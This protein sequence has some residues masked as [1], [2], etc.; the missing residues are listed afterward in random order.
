MSSLPRFFSARRWRLAS[1]LVLFAYISGHL[2]NH[3]LGLLSLER[4]EAML[5]MSMAIWQSRPGTILLYGSAL[6][7]FSLALRSIYI[8]HD[9]RFP[10]VEIV[11]FWAGFSLPLLLIGH[12]AVTRLTMALYDVKPDYAGIVSSIVAGGSQE[13][14]IA[15]LAPGWLHGCLGLWISL[16]HFAL[17]RRLQ[18]LLIA[19][20]VV[21]PILSAAGFLAMSRE[22]E[23]MGLVSALRDGA[24]EAFAVERRAELTAWKRDM[25]IGY[26]A[27]VTLALLLGP[28]R[29]GVLR[30]RAV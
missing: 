18:P 3:T 27:I 10:F 26:L 11:R 2:I 1:G 16:R 17:M 15:L 12:I 29:R 21:L 25:T 30:S 5:R 20:M 6:L 22:V 8:R 14:Q 28:I 9:W 4:A 23:A 24:Q 7:H 19:G 13:W